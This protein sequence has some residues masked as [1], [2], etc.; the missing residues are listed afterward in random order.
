M[1]LSKLR[2]HLLQ[3]GCVLIR[4]GGNHSIYRNP[5]TN[6]TAPVPRHNEIADLLARMICDQLGIPSVK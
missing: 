5:Q 6:Q 1:K 4:E 3:N 2:K